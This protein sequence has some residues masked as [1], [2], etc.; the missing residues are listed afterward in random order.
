MAFRVLSGDELALLDEKQ[1]EQYENDLI[2]Y[3]QRVAFVE[4]LE[5]HENT[6]IEPYDPHLQSITVMDRIEKRD[7]TT[8]EYMVS[9][10]PPVVKENI[11]VHPFTM[12]EMGAPILPELKA[13]PEVNV[14]QVVVKDVSSPKLP[15]VNKPVT[16]QAVP[17]TQLKMG[18]LVKPVLTI[19]KR[20]EVHVRHTGKM[21]IASPKLSLHGKLTVPAKGYKKIEVGKPKL[22]NPVEVDNKE[23]LYTQSKI[24][25]PTL[26]MV[27][28][29]VVEAGFDTPN[30][31]IHG[32][33]SDLSNIDTPKVEF[34]SFTSIDIDKL[35]LPEIAVDFMDIGSYTIP[36]QSNIAL[37]EVAKPDSNVAFER[38]KPIALDAS[39]LLKNRIPISLEDTKC[40]SIIDESL[41]KKLKD[42]KP[43]LSKDAKIKMETK[44]F[45]GYNVNAAEL[46]EVPKITAAIGN[47][48]MAP[49]KPTISIATIEPLS[50]KVN[51]FKGLDLDVTD[52]PS[53]DSLT[54]P[55][56]QKAVEELLPLLNESFG[57]VGGKI[58]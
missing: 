4:Q 24:K 15:L 45:E 46:S 1:R 50:V 17:T 47:F 22:P 23:I 42:V 53:F 8:P 43:S 56:A 52:V 5:L 37:P 3:Q 6:K 27:V 13:R 35:T 38:V 12:I 36:K 57:E 18:K 30:V 21:D 10:H 54:I 40:N 48:F 29:P 19:T 34:K 28:K 9:L 33:P 58:S 11:H 2:I 39:V 51:T 26:T 32:I 14:K 41:I 16:K 55:N 20:P 44:F 7:F 25:K 31:K 49:E